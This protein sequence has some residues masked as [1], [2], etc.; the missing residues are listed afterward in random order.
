MEQQRDDHAD[1]GTDP[2]L[3]PRYSPVLDLATG[4]V[5]GAE[6]VAAPLSSASSTAASAA[7]AGSLPMATRRAAQAFAFGAAADEG[8]WVAAGLRPDQVSTPGATEVVEDLL[9]SSGLPAERLVLPVAH[10]ELARAVEHGTAA[11]MGDLGIRFTV[12]GFGAEAWSS[13]VL[14]EVPVASIQVSLAGLQPDADDLALVRS[15]VSLAASCG[16]V[17]MGRDVDAAEQ[18]ALAGD[19]GVALL[20]GY[21]WG[22]PGSLAKL[23]GTWAR[24]PLSE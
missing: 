13:S 4:L 19:A 18:V 15:M 1:G 2:R 12:V 6:V 9:R 5:V 7:W 23:V 8:W 21:W 14:R 24:H 16:T 20:E 11:A 10:A 22:S 3:E 17:V